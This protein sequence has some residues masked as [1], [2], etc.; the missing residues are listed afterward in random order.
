MAATLARGETVLANA[1]R[2]PEVADLARCLV[3]M[4]ADIEG[5][6]TD[7]MTVKGVDVLHGA[8][9]AVVPDRIES[10]TYAAAAAITGGDVELVG[11]RLEI[12][13]AIAE[14][15]TAAGVSIAET[16]RARPRLARRRARSRAST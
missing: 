1:A 12:F 16:G 6:G 2:E 15:L 5:I 10:G 4:G 11:A 8:R 9:H 3:A 14:A 7:T 13:G